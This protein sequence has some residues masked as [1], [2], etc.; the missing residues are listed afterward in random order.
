[1]S[2]LLPGIILPN[3]I[4]IVQSRL[5]GAA[6]GVNETA[7]ACAQLDAGVK[8]AWAAKKADI[9]AYTSTEV[10]IFTNTTATF[11]ERGLSLEKELDA[12]QAKF[13]D[14]GCTPK[15]PRFVPGPPDDPRADLL[16]WLVVATVAVAGA[17]TISRVVPAF[18][19]LRPAPAPA[20]KTV[21]KAPERRRLAP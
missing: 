9:D 17:Y 10:S 2:G 18:A 3:D 14:A 12:W 4:R 1:M 20:K 11:Y 19:A 8:T 5:A 15:S 16:K 7:N 21:S 13:E 6:T